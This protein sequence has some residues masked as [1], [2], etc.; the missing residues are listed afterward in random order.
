METC[1]LAASDARLEKVELEVYAENEAALRIYDAVGFTREG[2]RAK[3]RKL[4]GRYQDI[5]LLA[6]WV[7]RRV[8]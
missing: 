3:A 7:D 2:I 1:L 5:V 8:P 4:E 6:L